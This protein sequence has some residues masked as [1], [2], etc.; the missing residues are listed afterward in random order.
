[1]GS[2]VDIL[3]RILDRPVVDMTAL[4]GN[5]DFTLELTP[6]DYRAILLRGAIAAGV[7]LPPEALKALDAG[8]DES[9]FTGIE[10]LGLK[11]DR[12]KAPVDVLVV[13]R[14]SKEP[15]EN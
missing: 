13:D 10:K 4:T 9:L 7:V 6:E 15:T 3:A 2:F 8:S 12:R 14:A 11:L 5:Y 1:M